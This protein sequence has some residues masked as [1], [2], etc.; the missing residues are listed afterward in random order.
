MLALLERSGFAAL[1]TKKILEIGCGKG[2][3]LPEF[4]KW[5]AQPENVSGVDLLSDRVGEARKL[6]PDAVRIH[7]ENAIELCFPDT[8]FDLVLQFTVFSSILDPGMKAQMAS[9]MMRVVK[10]DGLILWYDHHVNNPWNLEMFG[11]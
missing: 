6:C 1:D 3:W 7:R 8:A 4:I 11:V 10:T 2:Y 5:G 9:E